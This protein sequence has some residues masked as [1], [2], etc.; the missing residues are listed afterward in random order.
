MKTAV[1]TGG[2]RGIGK[3]IVLQLSKAGF[4]VAVVY[5]GNADAANQVCKEAST[6]GV[7]A[8]SYQCDVSNFEQVKKTSEA[9]AADFGGVDVLVN[10]AGITRDN[11]A[12]R[13]TEQEFD[14]VI[15]VNLKGVFNCTKHFMRPIMKSPSGRII[16]ISSVS[17]V[18]GNVGQINYSATKAAVVGITKTMA[19]ELAGKNVTVNAVAPGFI[20]TDM[21]AGLSENIKDYV[22]SAVLFKRMGTVAEVAAVVNFLASEGASYITGQTIIVDGGLIT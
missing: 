2:S 4:N 6:F 7:K 9:V 11:L 16:N 8:I 17:G 20:E 5:A 10:N 13:M 19:K 12:L 14:E 1:V 22:K 3:E 21:T 15:A 18:T